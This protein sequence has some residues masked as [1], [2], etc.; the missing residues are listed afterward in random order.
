MDMIANIFPR[1]IPTSL[2]SA[3]I[4]TA[5]GRAQYEVQRNAL[6]AA[7]ISAGRRTVADGYLLQRHHPGLPGLR[8]RAKRRR[9]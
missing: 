9:H 6:G 8:R 4:S 7:A 5:D 1:S 3:S 2:I